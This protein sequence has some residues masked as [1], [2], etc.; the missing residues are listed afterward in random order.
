MLLGCW[1]RTEWW[2]WWWVLMPAWHFASHL[3]VCLHCLLC[4]SECGPLKFFSLGQLAGRMLGDWRREKFY[5]LV[6]LCLPGRLLQ[7]SVASSFLPPTLCLRQIC[8]RV[9]PARHFPTDN[10]FC[11]CRGQIS[12]RFQRA[13]FWKF[14]WMWALSNKVWITVPALGE[15][16]HGFSFSAQWLEVMVYY[17][18]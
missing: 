18:V 7:L 10:F 15:L 6:P 3:Q 1:L 17:A 9:P 2:W 4:E 5:L 11:H 12:G 13:D 16:F 14:H 8:G